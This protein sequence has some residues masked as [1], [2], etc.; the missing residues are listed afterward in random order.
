MF[1]VI[2]LTEM[3]QNMNGYIS[4]S[5]QPYQ[6]LK[7]EYN[8]AIAYH[9]LVDSSGKTV[10]PPFSSTMGISPFSNYPSMNSIQPIVSIQ[11][12]P[13]AITQMQPY[14]SQPIMDSNLVSLNSL[15]P[16]LASTILNDLDESNKSKAMKQRNRFSKEEDEFLKLLV[17]E[18]SCEEEP[19]WNDIA[20]KMISRTARQCRE[21]YR[22]YLQ[23]GLNN[24]PWTLE[25]DHLLI[26]KYNEIGP[27][28]CKLVHFFPHRSDV[29]IKNH[30]TCLL[31]RHSREIY[32]HQSSH[33]C[34]N[35]HF[36]ED[37]SSSDE[38]F[39][40]SSDESNSKSK[41]NSKINKESSSLSNINETSGDSSSPSAQ[42]SRSGSFTIFGNNTKTSCGKASE[43]NSLNTN[44]SN[45][46]NNK[47]GN[48]YFQNLDYDSFFDIDFESLEMEFQ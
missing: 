5:S 25:E 47:S 30:Y 13:P 43:N 33:D 1:A 35:D 10:I 24:G 18:N 41:D 48:Q 17:E 34:F 44:I 37:S 19:N 38:K 9:N 7:N 16:I 6:W 45:V 11:S 39:H 36:N 27:Q 8:K 28:W 4:S 46:K 42:I 31:N 21:R 23:P 26:E 15:P 20:S 12:L 2:S 14:Q 3:Y 22:N 29:N 32:S 40:Q